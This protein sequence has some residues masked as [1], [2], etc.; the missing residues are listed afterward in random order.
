MV[1]GL[2][3]ESLRVFGFSGRVLGFQDAAAMLFQDI[4]IWL[5]L[6]AFG[7]L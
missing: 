5:G 7:T 3:L 2:E 1:L 4:G 6:A